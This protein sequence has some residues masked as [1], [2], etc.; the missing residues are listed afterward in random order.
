MLPMGFYSP[1]HVSATFAS[2]ILTGFSPDDMIKVELDNDTFE[3]E[4]GAQGDAV[5]VQNLN[6][7]ATITVTLLQT[8]PSNQVLSDA[9]TLD[10]GSGLYVKPFMLKDALGGTLVLAPNCWV[11]KPPGASFGKS[12]TPREWVLRTERLATLVIG[13]GL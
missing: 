1:A 7:S 6:E 5:R 2:A 3:L 11:Q 4:V 13:G 10:K 8:S 12:H 9:W